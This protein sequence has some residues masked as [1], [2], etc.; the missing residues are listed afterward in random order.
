VASRRLLE[1]FDS[2]AIPLLFVKG[3]TLGALAYG[4]P[5]VKSAIDVDILIDAADLR[6]ASKPLR[7]CGFELVAPSTSAGDGKLERWH[8][9]WKESVW[10]S[11]LPPVQ[12]DLHTR[13]A[14][15][16]RLIPTID[17]HAPRQTVDIGNELQ[18]PT[19]AA[20]E[21]FAYLAVHGASSAWFR[22]K[23]I[24]DFAGFLHRT[25]NAKLDTFYRRSQELGAGRAAGQ[26][27]LLVDELF[28]SLES[29]PG[30]R[31][32]LFRDKATVRLFHIA[33]RLMCGEPV[34]PT[35]RRWGTWPIHRTQFDLLPGVGF[36]LS[37]LSSQLRRR[38]SRLA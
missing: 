35:E 28:G 13:L 26:A 31:E 36:K 7:N 10:A 6:Q 11:E 33:L 22:L 16:P 24:S 8:R 4:N 30:L 20:E 27:L 29:E 1:A 5:A 19:L 15:N 21:L 14:D 32:E 38:T 25:G 23:W 17:V 2:A 34:E 18:L 9:H 12:L 37:E 3:L